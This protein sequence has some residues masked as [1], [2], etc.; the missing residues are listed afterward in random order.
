MASV[1]RLVALAI[2]VTAIACGGEDPKGTRAAS[3]ATQDETVAQEVKPDKE[4]LLKQN[5][6]TAAQA[7]VKGEWLTV[8]ALYPDEFKAKCS[9]SDF[10]AM[11]LF[12]MS[13]NGMPE[14]ATATVD[15]VRVEGDKGF[16]DIRF[17]KD[18][19]ELDVFDEDTD[20]ETPVFLWKD[21]R[22]IS[23]VSPEQMAEDKPCELAWEVEE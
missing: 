5:A 17:S 8:H 14:G 22:W 13:F 11:M 1:V 19:L 10:A 4:E 15:N 20:D 23:Y 6:E 3:S 12:A 2:I 9:G 21:N 16:A 18:G 7:W